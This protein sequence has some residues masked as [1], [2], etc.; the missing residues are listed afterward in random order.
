MA[1]KSRFHGRKVRVWAGERTRGIFIWLVV[2]YFRN[3]KNASGVCD[4]GVVTVVTVIFGL[5]KLTKILL[6]YI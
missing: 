2:K 6:L 1:G 3:N 5:K 4:D